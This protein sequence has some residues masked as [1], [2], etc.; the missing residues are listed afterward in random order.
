VG[1][2]TQLRAFSEATTAIYAAARAK[3][4]SVIPKRDLASGWEP[5]DVLLSLLSGGDEVTLVMPAAAGPWAAVEVLREIEQGFSDATT[6][7]GL[8]AEAFI[9]EPALLGR[10]A[11]AGAGGGLVAAPEHYPVRLLR[12]YASELQGRAKRSCAADRHRSSVAWTLLTD[13]SPLPDSGA[14]AGGAAAWSLNELDGLLQ[15]AGAAV[16]HRLPQAALH[17]LVGEMER[18]ARS[19]TP[20]GEGERQRVAAAL[21]ANF[22]RYQLGRS[23]ALAKWWAE[24]E[25]SVEPTDPVTSW[26]GRANGTWLRAL[27]DLLALG[28]VGAVAVEGEG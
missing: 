17:R 10:L 16:R 15:E 21:A 2:L 20:L 23:S 14:V 18:E 11:R 26:L 12:R 7:N 13:S 6:G 25:P 24:V 28:P 19:L 27:A 22:F 4:A 5:G 8:L 3:A 9:D 1:N